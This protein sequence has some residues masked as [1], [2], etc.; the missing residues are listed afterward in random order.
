MNLLV[1]VKNQ[2]VYE[3]QDATFTCSVAGGEE[4]S[5]NWSGGSNPCKSQTCTISNVN[6]NH[7]KRVYTCQ[8]HKSGDVKSNIAT[9]RLTV[10]CK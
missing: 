7:N 9:A 6:R 4:V 3:G 8:A 2:T 10:Y 5:Y 1:S